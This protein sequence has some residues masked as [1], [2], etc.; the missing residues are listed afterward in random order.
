MTSFKSIYSLIKPLI[1]SLLI[2]FLLGIS[3]VQANNH[4]SDK[5]GGQM[6]ATI[7][8][9]QVLFPVLKT[10]IHS[11]IQGNLATV[12]ISQTF[13]N[14]LQQAMHTQYLFPLNQNAAV[15]EMIMEVGDEKIVANIQEKQQALKTFQEAKQQGKSAAILQQ[16]RPNMF[17][18]D[19]ANLMPGL[20]IK[21]T[22]K[23]VQTISK[24]DNNYELVI[25]LVV[26]PRF[27]PENKVKLA[28]QK[29]EL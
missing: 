25:P 13:S 17:T 26:G 20:P 24:V 10:A 22:L 27:Q 15:Y 29:A 5:M 4:L 11:D 6:L 12:S 28:A 1:L 19:I 8:D 9:Q 23:Y 2:L 18:Q 21:V 14:P 16:H 7:A 3:N